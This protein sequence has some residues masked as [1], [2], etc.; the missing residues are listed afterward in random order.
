MR[1]FA[2]TVEYEPGADRLMDVFIERPS[3]RAGTITCSATSDGMWRVDRF[4]GPPDAIEAVDGVFSDTGHCNECLGPGGCGV[5][6]EYETL[7]GDSTSRRIYTRRSALGNCHSVPYLAVE[8]FG[9]GLAFDAERRGQQY[10][11]RVLTDP[12]ADVE[13]FTN[14]VEEGLRDG[15]EVGRRYAGKPIHW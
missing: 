10:E 1:E 3:L 14:T 7:G 2:F 12:D 6:R 11:W 15:L 9:E 13:A 4:T 5:T 8:R